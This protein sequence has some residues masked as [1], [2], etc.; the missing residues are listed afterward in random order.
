MK[1]RNGSRA[2]TVS[3]STFRARGRKPVDNRI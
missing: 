3:L 1:T 2:V